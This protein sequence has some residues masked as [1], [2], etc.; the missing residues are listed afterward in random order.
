MRERAAPRGGSRR[1]ALEERPRPPYIGWRALGYKSV[2]IY[3]SRLQ[4]GKLI[5]AWL[6][7]LVHQAVFMYLGPHVRSGR[8]NWQV[9]GS[10]GRSG[11]LAGDGWD[12]GR[13]PVCTHVSQAPDQ[14]V[15]EEAETRS[16]RSEAKSWCRQGR[17]GCTGIQKEKIPLMC[18]R[19]RTSCFWSVGPGGQSEDETPI[20]KNRRPDIDQVTQ[21]SFCDGLLLK[22]TVM[23]MSGGP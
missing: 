10:S 15:G 19:S 3:P 23:E 8:A 21:R 12:P 1:R 2:S 11:P 14:R 20:L 9:G 22:W 4:Y 6:S 13:G 17:L 7:C 18:A 16:C 5:R